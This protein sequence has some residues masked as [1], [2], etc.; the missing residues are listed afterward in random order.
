MQGT[1]VAV[2]VTIGDQVT[3]GQ[4]ICMLEAMKMENQIKASSDGTISDL[5]ITPGDLVGAGDTL[6]IIEPN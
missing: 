5:L 1:I 2:S 6:A 4:T 3:K